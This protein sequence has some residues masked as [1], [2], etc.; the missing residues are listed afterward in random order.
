MENEIE[1]EKNKIENLV[2]YVS[3]AV[4]KD[5]AHAITCKN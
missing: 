5:I 2:R 1:N 3:K 4:G